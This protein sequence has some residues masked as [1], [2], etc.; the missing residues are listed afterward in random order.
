V[1]RTIAVVGF[2]PA[3]R[4]GGESG[5]VRNPLVGAL[6]EASPVQVE[7][8]ER[9]TE[10][11]FTKMV[12]SKKYEFVTPGQ[13]Q[14]ALASLLSSNSAIGETELFTSLGKAMEADAVLV[15]YL[16]R[17]IE[18]EGADFGVSRPSSV[19]FD[20]YL[21]RTSNGAIIWKGGFDKTQRSLTENLLDFDTFVKAKGKWM[22]AE[23]LAELGLSELLERFPGG[24]PK[25]DTGE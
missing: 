13:A 19:A 10:S 3:V 6:H 7:F 4:P 5:L 14:G 17:W 8:V 21:I 18:R 25:G 11:L 12:A 24:Q 1:V 2:L 20:L 15:G 9:M 16:Y 23:S 22:S